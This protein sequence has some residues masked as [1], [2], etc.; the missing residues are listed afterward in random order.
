MGTGRIEKE[1]AVHCYMCTM[2]ERYPNRKFC[3]AIAFFRS[4]GW[5]K[6]EKLWLCP[7]CYNKYWVHKDLRQ[8]DFSNVCSGATK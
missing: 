3:D 8:K 7:Q 6:Q 5:S 1:L 2:I 4:E